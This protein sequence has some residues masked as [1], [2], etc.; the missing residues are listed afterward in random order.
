MVERDDL[1]DIDDT[2]PWEREDEDASKEGSAGDDQPGDRD[3]SQ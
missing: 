2:G 3:D 1:G